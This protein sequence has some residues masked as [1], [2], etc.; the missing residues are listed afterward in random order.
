MTPLTV[1]GVRAMCCPCREGWIWGSF[2]PILSQSGRQGHTGQAGA[3]ESSLRW[4]QAAITCSPQCLGR[5]VEVLISTGL[6]TLVEGRAPKPRQTGYLL[7]REMLPVDVAGIPGSRWVKQAK[8]L[9]AGCCHLSA[10]RIIHLADGLR[11]SC[12]LQLSSCK[13]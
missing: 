5:W 10:S 8:S 3:Q 6:R 13:M 11:E 12:G 4:L 2:H 7:P 9:S 1:T